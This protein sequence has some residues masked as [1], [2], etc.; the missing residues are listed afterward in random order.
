MFE[1]DVVVHSTFTRPPEDVSLQTATGTSV[2]YNNRSPQCSI[3]VRTF[4]N[5]KY[6]ERW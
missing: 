5:F 4:R 2:M 6:T 3:T 1:T